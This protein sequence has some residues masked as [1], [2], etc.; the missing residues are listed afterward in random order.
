MGQS[1]EHFKNFLFETVL[2]HFGDA[3]YLKL[4]YFRHHK[5]VPNLTSPKKFTEKITASKLESDDKLMKVCADKFAVREY[6]KSK[7]GNQYLIPMLGLYSD[8]TELEGLTKIEVPFVLKACHGSGWNCLI[9]EPSAPEVRSAIKQARAWM[10]WD[11]SIRG[12]ENQYAGIPR[13]VIAEEMLTA[14]DG[15]IPYD[16][17]FYCFGA[18]G[19]K[20]IF[21]QVDLDRYGDH[22]RVFRDAEWQEVP[23]A[24]LSKK[25][26]Q[27]TTALE[28]PENY[29]QMIEL[30]RKLASEFSFSRIDLYN[31]DGKIYFGEI[32]FHPESG[33]GMH[34][35][36]SGK[37]LELGALLP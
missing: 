10:Q 6:V 14:N 1:K 35:T 31:V 26:C 9:S 33:Y 8:E 34:V 25:S 20:L 36:P 5:R 16:Y 15:S 7:I 12:R 27:S 29:H 21:C 28:A 37:D 13:R 18:G 11:Y 2:R 3:T 24:V 4:R 32:T 17:K 22:Q 30:V 19:S 23:W